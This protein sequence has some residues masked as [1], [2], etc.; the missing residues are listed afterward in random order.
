MRSLG[1]CGGRV[2]GSGL[3]A[4][5]AGLF[6]SSLSLC[7]R[8][9]FDFLQLNRTPN[10]P[11]IFNLPL[12][13][14]T[15]NYDIRLFCCSDVRPGVAHTTAP[16]YRPKPHYAPLRSAGPLTSYREHWNSQLRQPLVQ[17]WVSGFLVLS[18]ISSDI[19]KA[20]WK[21]NGSQPRA[22]SSYKR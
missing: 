15:V 17:G 5:T 10:Q 20:S 21:K 3:S 9:P 4:T 18:Q 22:H 14:A 7:N 11:P 8:L 1:I 2:W 19:V 12:A 6:C 16:S 13:D